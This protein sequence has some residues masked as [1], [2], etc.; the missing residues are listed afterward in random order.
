MAKD[1]SYRGKTLEELKAMDIRE[2][3]KL[4]KSRNRRAIL[5]QTNEISSFINKC[6]E[7]KK[8]NKQIKTH[9]RNLVIVPAMID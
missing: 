6:E 9:S 8:K 5:R 1:F 3:A 2:F 4:V 7:L